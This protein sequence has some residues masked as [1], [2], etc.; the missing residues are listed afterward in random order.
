MAPKV[1]IPYYR[2]FILTTQFT[3]R[4]KNKIIY[5][6]LTKGVSDLGRVKELLHTGSSDRLN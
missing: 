4:R 2:V 5:H 1:R 6:G 3:T